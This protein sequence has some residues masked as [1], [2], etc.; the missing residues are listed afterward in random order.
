MKFVFGVAF[1]LAVLLSGLII[2][3][4][5][6]GRVYKLLTKILRPVQAQFVP[7]Q[8]LETDYLKSFDQVLKDK[9]WSWYQPGLIDW[10]LKGE[11]LE[12][13]TNQESMWWI[14]SNGSMLFNAVKGDVEISISVSA[15]KETDPSGFTD[16]AFQ[17]GGI[18]LR[19][20]AS[21][22]FLTSENYV[23]GVIGNRGSNGLQI[24]T[25]ST[26]NGWSSV[27]GADWDTGDVSIKIKR[28]GILFSIF[29]KSSGLDDWDLVQ[30]YERRDLPDILQLG[31]IVYSYS[32]G[33]G[34]HDLRVL[35]SDMEIRF[36]H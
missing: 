27:Q 17:F 24:E 14:N 6:D 19:D 33:K 21:D 12:V 26:Y 15:R 13:I 7:E 20:P 25:K 18:I 11:A 34:T 2:V 4:G 36:A 22:S 35:F 8:Y 23:F 28:S 5:K 3:Q 10:T 1:L 30:E 29:A 9:S 32:N 31:L 16:Q